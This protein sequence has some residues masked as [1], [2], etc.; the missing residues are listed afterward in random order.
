[1]G[2][3]SG[4][5][6]GYS[7]TSSEKLA[8]YSSIADSAIK[9]LGIVGEV[10]MVETYQLDGAYT[11]QNIANYDNGGN[12]FKNEIRINP[13]SKNVD[14]AIRHELRHLQQGQQGRYYQKKDVD[15]KRYN[16]WDG[17]KIISSEEF[18]RINTHLSNPKNYAKY[19]AFPWEVDAR[20]FE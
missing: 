8:K 17:K 5:S 11:A 4:Q 12:P 3:R 6:A 1:M 7:S 2:G 9:S 18:R 13:N 19:R 16:Y 14:K 20:S 15:G 10:K